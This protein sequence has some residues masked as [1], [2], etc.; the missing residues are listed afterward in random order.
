[1]DESGEIT[2]TTK[3]TPAQLEQGAKIVDAGQQLI[4][5]LDPNKLA[6]AEGLVVALRGNVAVG[7][8]AIK[9]A[10]ITG[11]A[12]IGYLAV[13]EDLRKHG[14]GHALTLKR[15]QLGRDLGLSMIYSNIRRTNEASIG[16]AR[17]AGYQ[18]WGDFYSAYDPEQVLSWFHLPLKDGIDTKRIM[19][20]LTAELT[21]A[22]RS[23]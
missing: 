2:Y 7:L 11:V 15:I 19:T 9:K 23:C 17:K 5:K 14:I 16:N 3:P 13:A 1:M 10:K 4:G 22:I 12:E 18:Y 8:A 20:K 6:Q 21:P